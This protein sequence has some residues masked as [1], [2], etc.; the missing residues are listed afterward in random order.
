MEKQDRAHSFERITFPGMTNEQ[1]HAGMKNLSY[2]ITRA[3]QNARK[4]GRILD[5]EFAVT[6]EVYY[7]A[8]PEALP[9]SE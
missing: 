6:L 2:L 4:V 1:Y 9:K 5:C 7:D 3:R 8:P